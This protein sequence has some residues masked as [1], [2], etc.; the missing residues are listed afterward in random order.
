MRAPLPSRW[1]LMPTRCVPLPPSYPGKDAW[2][3][4]PSPLP[5]FSQEWYVTFLGSTS[6]LQTSAR[7]VKQDISQDGTCKS[8][9]IRIKRQERKGIS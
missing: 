3:L 9:G 1:R 6:P 8:I 5:V 7:S 4:Q 2:P